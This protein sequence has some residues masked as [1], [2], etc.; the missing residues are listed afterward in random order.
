MLRLLNSLSVD[1]IMELSRDGL[2]EIKT[3]LS[4]EE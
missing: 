1:Q 4:K 3:K 2:S